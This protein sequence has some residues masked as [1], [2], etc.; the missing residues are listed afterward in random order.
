M[1]VS[2]DV[3]TRP[4]L[5]AIT[6]YNIALAV[7]SEPTWASV[8][9]GVLV[10]AE[11]CGVHRSLGRHISHVRSLSKGQWIPQQLAVSLIYI[12]QNFY[13]AE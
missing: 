9:R 13:F 10:C 4:V 1:E 8:N 12:L 6:F 11:C 5:S 2:H 7:Y 3:S